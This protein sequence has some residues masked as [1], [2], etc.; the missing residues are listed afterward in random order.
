MEENTSVYD[1]LHEAKTKFYRYQQSDKDTLT[2]HMYNFKDFFDKDMVTREMRAD[3][4]T[5]ITP[6][7]NRDNYR[8][9]V[10][11]KAKAVAFIK[12]SNRKL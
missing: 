3:V 2:D 9:R 7:M 11:D 6:G 10:I 8:D 5:G 1:A 12:S 4:T